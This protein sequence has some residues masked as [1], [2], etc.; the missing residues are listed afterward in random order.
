MHELNA[1]DFHLLTPLLDGLHAGT[2]IMGAVL[3]GHTRG[4][5][6]VPKDGDL[7]AAFVYD[8]GFCVL[9]GERPDTP[10]ATA[11]LDWLQAP[12]QQDFFILYPGHA[13]WE[14]VLDQRQAQGV[15]KL[16]RVAFSYDRSRFAAQRTEQPLPPG[17]RLVPLDAQ[18]LRH[19]ADGGQYPFASGMWASDAQFERDG[20]G[21]CVLHERRVA[22]LCYSVFVKG[23]R[24]DIDIC[25]FDGYRRLGLA[26]AAATAF[27]DACLRRGLEPGWDCFKGNRASYELAQALGFKPVHEFAVYSWNLSS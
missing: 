25:T 3:S 20:V 26:R 23:A 21:F 4:R 19:L 11:C 2:E 18:L 5:I 27:I 16:Q 24:H 10:F 12:A 17:H 1:E 6:F 8:N 15:Q 7:R 13:A 22:S 14:Q 9:A